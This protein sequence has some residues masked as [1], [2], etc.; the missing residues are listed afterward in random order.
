LNSCGFC[1]Q[2][3]AGDARY[4]VDC[5]KPLAGSVPAEA[6]PARE[7]PERVFKVPSHRRPSP[8]VVRRTGAQPA[9]SIL[10]PTRLNAAGAVIT[11][12]WCANVI[13]AGLPFCPHCG[14]RTDATLTT[15]AACP[16]CGN[17]VRPELD[18]FCASCGT[19]VASPEK[20]SGAPKKT[21]VFS[22][23]RRDAAARLVVLDE[24]GQPKQVVEVDRPVMTIGRGECDIA[25][26][27]DEYLSPRHAEFLLR[28]DALYV[29]D[30]GSANRT[31][32]FVDE[33]YPM[34]DEDVLLIGS[35]LFEFRRIASRGDPGKDDEG[36]R[37]IG[38]LTQSPDLALLAQLRADGSA[39]DIL[40][41]AGKRVV[42]I[43]R[44]TG[45]WLF[46]YDQTMSGRHAEVRA[47]DGAFVI[48]DLGSRNGVAVAARGERLLRAGA[49]VLA[50]DQVMR[51]E[52][53]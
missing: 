38:S 14:R 21:L 36:T 48:E 46:P 20:K 7:S 5:G 34:Q 35:Q 45:D 39:R 53:V 18:A 33:P 44:D 12:S 10:P 37:R 26:P 40:H 19:P 17:T 31:W 25:F 32:V 27:G 43:G 13:E 51:V 9:I 50:G 23:K 28:D 52:K 1:G 29:R 49:R 30:L 41:L 8:S 4:C 16:T 6:A 15:A 3:N 24:A 2:S 42:T 11:C 47:S 22:A